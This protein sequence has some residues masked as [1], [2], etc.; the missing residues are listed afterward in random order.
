MNTILSCL[1][2]ISGGACGLTLAVLF[3]FSFLDPVLYPQ[4]QPRSS[5]TIGNTVRYSMLCGAG[6]GLMLVLVSGQRL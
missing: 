6:I 5:E 2:G 1:V 4:H 3:L